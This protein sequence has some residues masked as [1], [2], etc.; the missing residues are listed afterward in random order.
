V[1]A[2]FGREAIADL[3]LT[4]AAAGSEQRVEAQ[5]EALGMRHRIACRRTSLVAIAE[6][7]GVDPK[8]GKRT[9][10]IAV[11]IPAGVSAEGSGLIMGAAMQAPMRALFSRMYVAPEMAIEESALFGVQTSARIASPRDEWRALRE[12]VAGL[13]P[14]T[15]GLRDTFDRLTYEWQGMDQA[16]LEKLPRFGAAVRALMEFL[17]AERTR[18]ATLA[19]HL[20]LAGIPRA[21][22]DE[23]IRRVQNHL[24]EM[25]E[26]AE[27]VERETQNWFRDPFASSQGFGSLRA[28]IDE[29][30]QGRH[31]QEYAALVDELNRLV[32]AEFPEAV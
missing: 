3:E 8:A 28:A 16:I 26:M 20:R 24:R 21:R 19:E 29:V 30:T 17:H 9:E 5:I 2:L 18:Y 12:L 11:E 32:A 22:V 27:R 13:R 4:L 25:N 7:P 10:R 14:E 31:A 23:L 1:G 6:E 15:S